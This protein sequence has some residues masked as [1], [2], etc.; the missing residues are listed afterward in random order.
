MN[1]WA[2]LSAALSAGSVVVALFALYWSTRSA[3]A[4]EQ[5]AKSAEATVRQAKRQA[6]AAEAGLKSPRAYI[7]ISSV[8]MHAAADDKQLVFKVATFNAG[9][10]PA[11]KVSAEVVATVSKGWPLSDEILFKR[12][13]WTAWGDVPAGSA[14]FERVIAVFPNQ[15]IP[16]FRAPNPPFIAHHLDRSAFTLGISAD[17]KL[18]YEDVYGDKHQYDA[19]YRWLNLSPEE[20]GTDLD[21][22]PVGTLSD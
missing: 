7:G 11:V 2:A 6:D 22:F 9:H 12:F 5:S 13:T 15:M 3:H 21:M 14:V 10:S 19:T 18:R 20:V 16:D 8:K 1:D 17:L 4:S